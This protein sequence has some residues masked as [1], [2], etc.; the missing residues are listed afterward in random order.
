MSAPL[1]Q[2]VKEASFYPGASTAALT[3]GTASANV[4]IPITPYTQ[5]RF[6]NVGTNVVYIALGTDNTVTAGIPV[7]GTPAAGIPLLPNAE[8]VLST[9]NARYVAALSSATG[10]TLF[11]TPGTGQ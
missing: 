11:I 7:S 10:N 3:V 9:G 5:T 8:R 6:V 4:A 1:I 2:S